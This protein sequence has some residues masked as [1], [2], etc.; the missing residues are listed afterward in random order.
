MLYFYIITVIVYF[1]L[2][3]AGLKREQLVHDSDD[4]GY[5]LLAVFLGFFPIVNFLIL[6]IYF[7]KRITKNVKRKWWE[8]LLFIY[9]KE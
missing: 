8:I 5:L 4:E 1:L 6:M 3:R 7:I 2:L 9:P